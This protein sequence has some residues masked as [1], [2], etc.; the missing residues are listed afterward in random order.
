[1]ASLHPFENPRV[2]TISKDASY[3]MILTKMPK[4]KSKVIDKGWEDVHGEKGGIKGGG[5]KG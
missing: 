3:W 2:N 4:M 5:T 1:M